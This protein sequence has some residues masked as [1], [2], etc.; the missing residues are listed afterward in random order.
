MTS[1]IDDTHGKPCPSCG[2]K[3]HLSTDCDR[4]EEMLM[5]DDVE[6]DAE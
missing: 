3:H 2:R 4:F 5:K 1:L 6:D